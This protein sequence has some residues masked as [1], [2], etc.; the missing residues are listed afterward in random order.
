VSL[1]VEAAPDKQVLL[2]GASGFV[3]R[4]LAPVLDALGWRVRCISRDAARAHQQWPQRAWQ[5]ADIANLDDVMRTLDGCRVGYYLVHSLAEN[6]TGLVEHERALAETFAIAA[7]R[8][9]VERI[10]YLGATEPQGPPSDHLRSRLEAGRVLRS[11]RVPTL[12]L[13]AG[14]IVGYGS[15]SWQIVRELAARLPA[16]VLPRWLQSRSQ[17]VAIEDVIV[18]LATAA[19]VPLSGSASFDLPGP[20]IMTYRETLMRTA[21]LL[22]HRRLVVVDVPV[23]TPTLSAQWIRLVTMADWSVARELVHGLR[24]DLLARG[25]EYWQL[26]AHAPLVTFDEAARSAFKEESRNPRTGRPARAIET[27]VDLVTGSPSSFAR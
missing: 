24:Y 13:R 8:V 16:M 5:Q 26:I 27:A 17:P 20:E 14:M 10:V 2:T 22:G 15:A 4:R 9:G 7:E 1:N 3:G 11:G 25:D 18:A 23:L 12:E 19:R 21:R 6:S